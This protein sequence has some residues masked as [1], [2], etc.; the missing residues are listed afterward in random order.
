MPALTGGSFRDFRAP[1]R[2][3][4]RRPRLAAS[5]S[6]LSSSALRAIDFEFLGF[7]ASRYPHDLDG[8]ADHVGGALLALRA[9]RAYG[10]PFLTL[11]AGYRRLAVL[12]T[13]RFAL[14]GG[15]MAGEIS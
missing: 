6:E 2:R 15:E 5:A 11:A 8:V 9:L 12:A 4:L 1:L 3:H 7:L 13:P 10:T 14:L